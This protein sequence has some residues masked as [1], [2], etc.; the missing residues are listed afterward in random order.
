MYSIYQLNVLQY[1]L[2]YHDYYVQFPMIMMILNL[3][4]QYQSNRSDIVVVDDD[5]DTSINVLS[6]DNCDG[7][8]GVNGGGGGRT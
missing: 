8:C 6:D 5:D 3:M 1:Y 2:Y 7:D 4:I